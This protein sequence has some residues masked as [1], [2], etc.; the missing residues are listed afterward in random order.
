MVLRTDDELSRNIG[1]AIAKNR[2]L[3][4]LTQAQVAEYLEIS[5]D[6]VSRMER[7]KIMPTVA[8]LM[9]MA[10][11]FGCETADLLTQS[12]VLALDQSRR[13]Q[14]LLAQLDE[15]ERVQLLEIVE[16]MVQWYQ[17]GRDK[18]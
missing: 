12:S 1:R 17:Q 9:Q 13:I 8:R 6:A 4:G 16:T 10:D 11:I 18:K 15:K 5:N 2:Q 14:Q 3:A 7:G